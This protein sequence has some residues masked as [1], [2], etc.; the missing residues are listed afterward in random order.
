MAYAGGMCLVVHHGGADA[1]TGTP[2]TRMLPYRTNQV[3]FRL[4]FLWE[5]MCGNKAQLC[6]LPCRIVV[7]NWLLAHDLQIVEIA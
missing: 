4:A 6:S 7:A 5:P 1:N 2:V 3:R